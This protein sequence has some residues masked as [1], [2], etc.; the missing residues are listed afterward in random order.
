MRK[1][2]FEV[3]STY[4]NQE[5]ELPQRATK[6]AAGYD[7]QAA[8]TVILPS[9]WPKLFT[10][11]AQEL[12]QWIFASQNTQAERLAVDKATL[13]KPILV[14]TGIKAY[15]PEDEYLQLVNRSSNPLK[16]FL[17]LPNGI[18]V[19]DADYYDNPS[20]E[21]HIYVQLLNFG[22][23]DQTIHKGDRIAQ[24]IFLPFLKA[25]NDQGGLIQ[26]SGGFGSSD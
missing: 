22:L 12:K 24:A 17:I 5:I 6:Q 13:L 9:F 25:D 11:L 20:N 2:G 7:L 18:G 23:F 26:R 4:Q 16:R 1:R 14:P 8:E 19:I 10:F 21:G 15:M 3:I